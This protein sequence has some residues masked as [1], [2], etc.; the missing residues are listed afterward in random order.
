MRVETQHD[1]AKEVPNIEMPVAFL[2][3]RTQSDSENG[4]LV[5]VHSAFVAKT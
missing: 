3:P 5:P 1:L 2:R 4:I